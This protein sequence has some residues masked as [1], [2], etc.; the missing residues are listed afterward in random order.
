MEYLNKNGLKVGRIPEGKACP[1][2]KECGFYNSNRCPSADNL[3]PESFDCPTA[4][5][6]S[7][8]RL[9]TTKKAA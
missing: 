3:K 4:R 5:G 9:R 7:L 2:I 8:L 1:F 6:L